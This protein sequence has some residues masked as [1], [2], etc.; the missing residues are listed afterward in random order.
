MIN[1]INKYKS[2]CSKNIVEMKV[3]ILVW[4]LIPLLWK[5]SDTVPIVSNTLSFF[6]GF[7]QSK[8]KFIKAWKFGALVYYSRYRSHNAKTT[9]P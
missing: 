3:N 4:S 5:C 7:L 1:I 2:C 9:M 6:G 8:M